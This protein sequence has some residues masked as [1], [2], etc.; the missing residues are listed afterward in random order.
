MSRGTFDWLLTI[1]GPKLDKKSNPDLQIIPGRLPVNLEK[2]LL[3]TLWTLATPDSY[4][5]ICDRFNVGKATGLRIVRRVINALISLREQFI[6]WPT[7]DEAIE[8]IATF[9]QDKGFPNVIGAI[10]GTHIV[11]EVE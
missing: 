5:S 9:K 3:I 2:Q 1:V 10:D 4:R 7:E 11:I 8:S 6:T